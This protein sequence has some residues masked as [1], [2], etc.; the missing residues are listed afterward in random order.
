[1]NC[2]QV[3]P[4]ALDVFWDQINP[5]LEKVVPTTYERESIESIKEKIKNK[6]VILWIIWNDI[7]DIKGIVATKIIVYPHKRVCWWGFMAAKDNKIKEWFLV[8]VE[9]LTKYSQAN[10]C[11]TIEFVGRKGWFKQFQR[12]NIKLQNIGTI[13]EGNLK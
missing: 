3:N 8:M 7:S 11:D 4:S 2:T 5:L 13:Y 6:E 12:T 10:D 1:M 9:S